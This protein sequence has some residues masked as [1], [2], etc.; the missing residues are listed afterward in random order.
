MA[1][2]RAADPSL[3]HD[4]P[5]AEV[6]EDQLRAADLVLVNKCDAMDDVSRARL[7]AE[8]GRLIP[9][10]VKLLEISE[11]RVDP[12]ILLGLAAGSED[13]L[14]ARPSHHERGGRRARA[15]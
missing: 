6:F 3:D 12:A 9:R 4:N 2:Q 10:A 7:R 8:I 1:A 15:R 5:L 14:D 11:G 13:D